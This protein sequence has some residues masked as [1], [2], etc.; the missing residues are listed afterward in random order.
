MK[1][2]DQLTEEEAKVIFEFCKGDQSYFYKGLS[3]EPIIENG[4]RQVTWGF[5]DV[6]GI[7]YGND[8]NDGCVLPF[9]DSKVVYCLYKLDYDISELLKKNFYFSEMESDFQC[10]ADDIYYMAVHK[11]DTTLEQLKSLCNRCL[12]TYY[13]KDYKNPLE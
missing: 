3:F 5:T 2:I 9:T 12:E 6:I 4:E 8:N 7:L 1:K 10:F 11:Q 13:Y